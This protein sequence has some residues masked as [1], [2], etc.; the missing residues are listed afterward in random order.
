M[1]PQRSL[2]DDSIWPGTGDQLIL[3]D[4]LAGALDQRDEDVESPAAEAERFSVLKQHTLSRNQVERSEGEAFFIHREI[5]LKKQESRF[6]Q[7]G[8][9]FRKTLT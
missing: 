3:A 8:E 9:V 5:G 6:I 1:D 4:D 7:A 2:I